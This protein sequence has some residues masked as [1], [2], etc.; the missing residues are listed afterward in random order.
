M[1]RYLLGKI[2][3]LI[4]GTGNRM[5]GVMSDTGFVIVL[6]AESVFYSAW[7]FG[8][9]REIF[10]QMYIAG[11]KTLLVVSIV[12]L[13][14]GM[15][16]TLQSGIELT[17]TTSR[18]PSWGTSSSP[19]MTREMGPFTAA[20]IL[21]A[22]VGSA[23][24]AET[25]HHEGLRGDRRPGDDVHQPRE[26]PGDAPGR[27][28]LHHDARRD[29]LRRTFW[30]PWAARIVAN[31]HLLVSFE[32]FYEHVLESLQFKAIYVGLLKS[33]VFGIIISCISCA[34]GL[35]AENGALGVGRPPGPPWSPRSS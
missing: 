4:E 22:S 10:K 23:M 15:I 3:S 34:Q 16:L 30:V 28:P 1:I 24:A 13:F 14:T 17:P 5:L 11:V 31:S 35:R 27:G 19:R 7:A 25:R 21:I 32:I 12:A 2:V 20:I 29:D 18:R 26:I 8:K 9:W 6:F 33:F